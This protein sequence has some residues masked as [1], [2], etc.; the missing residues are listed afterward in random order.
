MS[1]ESIIHRLHSSSSWTEA[2]S[3]SLMS[4]ASGQVLSLR[5]GAGMAVIGN[6]HLPKWVP[7][8]LSIFL[9]YFSAFLSD[10]FLSV[11]FPL[12]LLLFL[13]LPFPLFFSPSCHRSLSHSFPYCPYPFHSLSPWLHVFLS[14][15]ISLFSLSAKAMSPFPRKLEEACRVPLVSCHPIHPSYSKEGTGFPP[16]SS[17]Y[18]RGPQIPMCQG[19]LDNA[20]LASECTRY[21]LHAP[22]R[23]PPWEVPMGW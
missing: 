19:K 6:W 20:R 23:G 9:Y 14:P 7:R 13:P 22:E 2:A 18:S 10:H 1:H 3:E 4:Y 15:S 8:P 12:T 11:S 21:A 17:L 5:R 16:M